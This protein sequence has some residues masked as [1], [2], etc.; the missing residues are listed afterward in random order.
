MLELKNNRKNDT[1]SSGWGSTET[2]TWAVDTIP[3]VSAEVVPAAEVTT[4]PG[5]EKYRAIYEFYA[6]NADEISFQPGDF[7]MV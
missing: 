2:N 3:P 6:R 7:V 4:P 1:Y 5:Y